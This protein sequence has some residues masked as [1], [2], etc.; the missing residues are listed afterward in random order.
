MMLS[1]TRNSHS[2]CALTSSNTTKSTLEF[3]ATPEGSADSV[4][5]VLPRRKI[6]WC[7]ANLRIAYTVICRT[8][9]GVDSRGVL[10]SPLSSVLPEHLQMWPLAVVLLRPISTLLLVVDAQT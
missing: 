9:I 3:L 10:T 5:S 1:W 2:L 7:I 8:N 4:Q 6:I